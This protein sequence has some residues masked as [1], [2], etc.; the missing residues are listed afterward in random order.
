MK[1]TGSKTVDNPEL[2]Y[3]NICKN[4]RDLLNSGFIDYN[5][6][7]FFEERLKDN[8][9]TKLSVFKSG[10]EEWHSSLSSEMVSELES[11]SYVEDYDFSEEIEKI[12]FIFLYWGAMYTGE[13]HPK[14]PLFI[15]KFKDF[16]TQQIALEI[17][18]ESIPIPS[19]L[20]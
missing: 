6:Y 2:T 20:S 8:F 9:S 13:H 19:D 3:Q 7:D 16:D 10:L 1:N 5:L 17:L 18:V 12:W 4:L 11:E 14:H 15:T